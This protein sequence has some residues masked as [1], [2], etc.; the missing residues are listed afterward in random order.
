MI[1]FISLIL[2]KRVIN[3]W[4]AIILAESRTLNEIGRIRFLIDSTIIINGAIVGGVLIG[5]RCLNIRL[6]KF[7]HLY[8]IKEI[9]MG[10]PIAIDTERC[11]VGVNVYGEIPIKLMV[12]IKIKIVCKFNINCLLK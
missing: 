8:V 1:V 2:P 12:K 5:K 11:L 10:N 4:P 7:N 6:V 9:Q 3:R